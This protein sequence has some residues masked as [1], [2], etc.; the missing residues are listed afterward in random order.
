MTLRWKFDGKFSK[1]HGLTLGKDGIRV[2]LRHHDNEIT[3]LVHSH[4]SSYESELWE[5]RGESLEVVT[6][7]PRKDSPHRE[8]L[9]VR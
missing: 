9:A 2:V 3:D 7:L 5:V 6:N 8:C 1:T 4:L